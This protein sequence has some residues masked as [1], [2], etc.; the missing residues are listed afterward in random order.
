[1]HKEEEDDDLF[2]SC[3][4]CYVPNQINRSSPSVPATASLTR[5]GNG[6]FEEKMVECSNCS[7][8]YTVYISGLHS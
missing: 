8:K 3:P 7:E 1:M 6:T 5:P 4:E 2:V